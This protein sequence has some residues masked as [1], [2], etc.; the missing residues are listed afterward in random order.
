MYPLTCTRPLV[1]HWVYRVILWWGAVVTHFRLTDPNLQIS[2]IRLIPVPSRTTLALSDFHS[3]HPLYFH[4][5]TLPTD[6]QWRILE[7]ILE[8]N[9]I[10]PYVMRLV[11]VPFPEHLPNSSPT[12]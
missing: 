5:P 3:T 2:Q 9:H 1:H 6:I 7:F 4:P 12:T 8:R 11:G 10:L